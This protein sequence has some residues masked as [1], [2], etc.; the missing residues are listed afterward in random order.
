MNLN[1][2]AY[3]IFHIAGHGE[4]HVDRSILYNNLDLFL[5]D[6]IYKIKSDT[7]L[8]SNENEYFKFN[9]KFKMLNPKSKFKWGELGIWASNL[10]AMKAFLKTNKK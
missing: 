4:S 6:K 1:D 8:I 9:N 2:F 3:K 7:I 10:L 5:S